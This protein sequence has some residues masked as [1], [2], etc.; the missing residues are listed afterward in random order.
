MFERPSD[1]VSQRLLSATPLAAP[2]D[3]ETVLEMFGQLSQRQHPDPGG[4]QLD[5]EGNAVDLGADL[6]D[7]HVV[8]GPRREV[9]ITF[10]RSLLEQCR[11][12][13]R[14]IQWRKPVELLTANRNRLPAGGEHRGPLDPQ[15][16]TE[17]LTDRVDDVLATVEDE[18]Q[19]PMLQI[20]HDAVL[21][22]ETR[23]HPGTERLR[24][25]VG[26]RLIVAHWR[27]FAHHHTVLEMLAQRPR[28][29]D[30]KAGLADAARTDHGDHPMIAQ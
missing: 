6:T 20:V 28:H 10:G 23:L 11:T 22:A 4:R 7:E 16:A 30:D 14:G 2:K 12:G 13:R 17:E 19:S 24:H 29:V 3:A 21:E 8:A 25:R 18:Q 1:R 26:D 15:D 27:Q 5:R 9:G